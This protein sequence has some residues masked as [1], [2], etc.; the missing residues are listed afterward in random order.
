MIHP[1]YGVFVR[2]EAGPKPAAGD[3]LEVVRSGKVVAQL[4]VERI[5]PAEKAYPE[6]CAVCR[7]AGG[8]AA[9]GDAVR[10]GKR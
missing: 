9:A 5:T 4:T 3:V 1:E 6:G 7:P 2:L 10:K 8:E